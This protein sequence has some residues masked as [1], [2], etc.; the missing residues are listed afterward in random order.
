VD[1]LKIPTKN[2]IA[3]MGCERFCIIRKDYFLFFLAAFLV[4]F[5]LATFLAAF[6]LAGIEPKV[7]L[8]L[9]GLPTT[10]AAEMKI[11]KYFHS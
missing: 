9:T 3:R 8:V 1:I 4:A 5:F 7:L 10:P 11:K 2:K 6:F